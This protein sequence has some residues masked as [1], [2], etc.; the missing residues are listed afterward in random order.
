MK[1]LFGIQN[2]RNQFSMSLQFTDLQE[3]PIMKHFFEFIQNTEFYCMKG[4]GLTEED[5]DCFVSQIKYDKKGKYEPNL[6]IK[7]PFHKTSFQ[8]EIISDHSSNV[9][10]L[11]IQGFAPMKCDIYL[12]K[13]WRMD[14]NKGHT[15]HAKWKCKFIHLV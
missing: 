12:D 7:L 1:C 13:I 5:A 8:T 6:N 14:I 15:F 11:Q 2:N 10:L 9:N 4:L 3:D